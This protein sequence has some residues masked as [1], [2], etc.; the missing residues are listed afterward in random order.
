MYSVILWYLFITILGWISFPLAYRLLP[1]L[2]DR[3]YAS[4]RTLGL[5]LWCFIFWLLASLGILRNEAGG[6]LFS[7]ALLIML[8]GW[9]IR[10]IDK[11]EFKEWL[12]SQFSLIFTVELMFLLAFA[13]WAVVRAA[14]PEAVGTEKPMELAFINAI[15]R[16]PTFPPHDPWLSGFAISYY[17][18]G[19][20]MVAMLAKITSTT[21]GVA[22]NLGVSLI[23]ALCATGSYG[24]VYNLLNHYAYGREKDTRPHF[25]FSSILGPLF[26]LIVS[27]LEGFLDV[28]H[29]RGILWQRS[30]TG[31]LTSVFWKWVDIKDLDLPP[32]EPFSWIPTRFWWWWRAS[33][34]LQDYD[35]VGNVKEIIDEFPFFSYLLADL[36]PHV[37]AM[38]FAFLAM[39][40]AFNAFL[41]GSQEKQINLKHRI[42]LRT[43][44]W[45][46]T[47]AVPGSVVLTVLG[48]VRLSVAPIGL[49]ILGMICSGLLLV[50]LRHILIENGIDVF[51]RDDL[52][53]ITVGTII[54]SDW[55]GFLLTSVTLG[56]LAFLNTWDFP[57]YVALYSAAYAL[58]RVTREGLKLSEALKDFIWI[59]LALGLCGG[60]L[61]L[62]FYL[63]FS[64]QVG[65][66]LPNLIYPTRGVHLWIMFAQF[67]IPIFA[68]LVYLVSASKIVGV[69]RRGLKWA[70]IIMTI[71]WLFSFF[72]GLAIIIV[73]DIGDFY[74]SS[75]ASPGIA[76]LF[77]EALSR[78]F[79]NTGGWITL[80]FLLALVLALL[81]SL[82]KEIVNEADEPS[83]L[84]PPHIF[85]LLLILS[86]V[87][88]VIGPEFIYLR[89][90]FGWRMNTI[91][92]FY[93]QSWLLWSISAAYASV[94][95][96]MKLRRFWNI[97]ITT[98]FTLLL[99]MSLAYPTLSLWNKTNG[100]NPS[101][102]TLD[103]TAYLN[104]EL[105]D[106]VS[107]I[108]WLKMAPFG[109][110]AEAV[111]EGGG[112]YTQYGR[113]STHSGLPAVL[114]WIGHENQWRGGN[115]IMG[116]RQED[117][118]RLYCSRDWNET[119]A[120][121]DQYHIRYIFM[122]PLERSTY[123]SRSANCSVGLVDVK[124]IRNLNRVFEQG[125]VTI[126]EYNK[127][128]DE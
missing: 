79:L 29:T 67:L 30:A 121:L 94:V 65:G 66:I 77:E 60:L 61:Y 35:M 102:W 89:D 18:F 10:G 12:R 123:T 47:L 31:E 91:F 3:G 80:L 64:S 54:Q 119:K 82:D 6:L 34:V 4:S 62:P 38:P 50:R 98:G 92:K 90:M 21:G 110:V 25:T 73:P 57:L 122:S 37:L 68:F 95:L 107:A 16:S 87:L 111:P 20:V 56:G 126:Y 101:E 48:A 51:L 52:G 75:L 22:F 117:L 72:L 9:A 105:P 84:P 118:E 63:G 23:F 32:Q 109:V 2:K 45:I 53:E 42:N 74:Q 76:A 5:L 58:G 11:Q 14:N 100:F 36:H 125:A 24:L 104:K 46:G 28:L 114:G 78:R 41:G 83:F 70:V 55:I 96:L 86:G 15:L 39:T 127:S 97:V 43:L 33:R 49:G 106:E 40:L 115:Q 112:S 26:V 124:F 44:A 128:S 116:S 103:S 59:G 93:F 113:V 108:E 81:L 17:Y 71:L 120:I 85:T 88:L 1:A 27:N 13:G 7:L 99:A 8:S 69:M 19:Y